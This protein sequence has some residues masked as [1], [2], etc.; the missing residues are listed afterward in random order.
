MTEDAFLQG[1]ARGAYR[2][3]SENTS[4]LSPQDQQAYEDRLAL[5]LDVIC[6]M[7]FAGYF[8]NCS[9]F[10]PLVSAPIVF[11][12]APGSSGDRVLAL[13]AYVLGITNFRTP[14]A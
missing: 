7:G 13:V 5:E 4:H 6:R 2:R 10:Y 11:P 3:V 1:S 8:F 14:G 9:R 12:S